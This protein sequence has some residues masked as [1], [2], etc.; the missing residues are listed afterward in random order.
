MCH[1]DNQL[2]I[3]LIIL[4]GCRSLETLRNRNIEQPTLTQLQQQQQ[5]QQ[6]QQVVLPGGMGGGLLA[7]DHSDDDMMEEEEND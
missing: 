7:Q 5:Q 6:Q 4:T 1:Y 3:I 2:C